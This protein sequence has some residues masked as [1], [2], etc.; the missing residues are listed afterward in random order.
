MIIII[1][2]DYLTLNK[3]FWIDVFLCCHPFY[4]LLLLRRDGPL[5]LN[6]N[7]SQSDCTIHES[8]SI[9]TGWGYVIEWM[10]VVDIFLEDCG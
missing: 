8:N 6:D 5:L 2:C 9:C 10:V 4:F 1:Y 3:S 7:L